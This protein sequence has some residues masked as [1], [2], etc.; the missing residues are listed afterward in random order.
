[1]NHVIQ[2]SLF[3]FD[4][5]ERFLS[6]A[7][8]YD[9]GGWTRIDRLADVLDPGP[10]CIQCTALICLSFHFLNWREMLGLR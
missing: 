8:K 5:T 1:M 4:K 10:R 7:S 3:P 9:L 6:S 2:C